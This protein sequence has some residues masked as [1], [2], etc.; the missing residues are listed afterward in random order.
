MSLIDPNTV[1]ADY[2]I[3]VSTVFRPKTSNRLGSFHIWKK[4]GQ[5]G[6]A[7]ELL[8]FCPANGCKGLFSDSF[9]LPAN[10][11][12]E[13]GEENMD[14]VHKW[15]HKY[16]ALYENWFVSPVICPLCGTIEI[17]ENLPDSYGFNM[18]TGKIAGRMAEFYTI[19]GGLSDVYMVRT[20]EN[21]LH[22]KA[23]E[24][25]N[26]QADMNFKKY[27]RTLEQARDRDC[28]YYPLKSIITDTVGGGDLVKRFKALLEA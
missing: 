16:Q 2:V 20:K 6:K 19:L 12:D 13:I 4:A 1:V 14:D 26:S 17:R 3:Q 27:T 8:K 24:M 22:H 18:D 10:S 9:S 23:R 11:I 21:H 15:P 28:V 25:L 7:D 5:F